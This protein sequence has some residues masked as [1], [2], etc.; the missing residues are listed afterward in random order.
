MTRS[1]GTVTRRNSYF[2]PVLRFCWT[3]FFFH[4]LERERQKWQPPKRSMARAPHAELLRWS[5]SVSGLRLVPGRGDDGGRVL[6]ALGRPS[7]L[8]PD[9][10]GNSSGRDS[11]G[12]LQ[13]F[14]NQTCAQRNSY[15]GSIACL[16]QF[17]GFTL[18][19]GPE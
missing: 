9:Y 4:G 15:H 7:R 16:T 5:T 11:P 8:P 3:L 6:I 2:S 14:R 17:A 10:S 13:I 1:S 12:G 18:N 19:S